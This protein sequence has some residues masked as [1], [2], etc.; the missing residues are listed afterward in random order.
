MVCAVS[1]L[2]DYSAAYEIYITDY[3]HSIAVSVGS[4]Q[5][6]IPVDNSHY[7]RLVW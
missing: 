4:G 1:Q 5:E 6:K 7:D 2:Q 3:A